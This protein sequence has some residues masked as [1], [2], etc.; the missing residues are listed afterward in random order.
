MSGKKSCGDFDIF[1]VIEGRLR[2]GQ[3]SQIAKDML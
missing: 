3:R 1:E 2:S